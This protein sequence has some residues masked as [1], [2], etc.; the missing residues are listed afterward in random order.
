[1][2]LV[3]L[4]YY[5]PGFKA[6]GPIPAI[7]NLIAALGHEF[8]FHVLTRDRDLGDAHRYPTLAHDELVPHGNGR[9][10]YLSPRALGMASLA[11]E[12]GRIPYDLL[13]LNSLFSVPFSI[14][15]LTLRRAGS[16]E[17]RPVVIAPRGECAPA[18]LALNRRRKT[19]YL[20]V[21]SGSGL[22]RGLHWQASGEHERADILGAIGPASD[23]TIAPELTSVPPAASAVARAPR[24]LH[25]A[26]LAFLGRISPM[27]NLHFAIEV[28]A[29]V[30]GTVEFDVFGPIED[31]SYWSR[32]LEAIERLPVGITVHHHGPLPPSAVSHTLA[33]YD[34]LFLP[35]LGENFGFV[36]VE[37]MQAGC[38]VL[39]SDRTR[40]QALEEHNAGWALPL[41]E[42]DAF[43]D[44]IRTLCASDDDA[45][46]RR[47]EG[48][49]AYASTFMTDAD[50]V[51]ATRNL[52][53]R[54]LLRGAST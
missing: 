9:V 30:G 13:Y 27:K 32:C 4:D 40:W 21:A 51:D 34:A 24:A 46:E 42:P 38:P 36:I 6:G 49:T 48:A 47:R 14:V 29:R 37:A 22:F 45:R 52:F 7:R 17:R 2:V 50:A 16:G 12:F 26:R 10:Q 44:V 1:V 41:D 39:I 11:R 19:A 20:T 54:A 43:A 23:V 3:A 15:P 5:L 8:D 53:Q 35:S 18:A 28:L 33:R 25:G 31:A